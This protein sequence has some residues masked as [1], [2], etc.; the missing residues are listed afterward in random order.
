MSYLTALIQ[1]SALSII[2]NESNTDTLDSFKPSG[3]LPVGVCRSQLPVSTIK[4]YYKWYL[5]AI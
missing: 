4:K 5:K 2:E 1:G 3:V